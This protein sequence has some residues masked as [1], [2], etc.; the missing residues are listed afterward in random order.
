MKIK[1]EGHRKIGFSYISACIDLTE[2]KFQRL[3]RERGESTSAR[4]VN[5]VGMNECECCECCRPIK[6]RVENAR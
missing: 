4:S 3:K 6:S 1:D 5:L 2:T